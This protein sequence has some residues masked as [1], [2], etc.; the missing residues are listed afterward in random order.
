MDFALSPAQQEIKDRAAGFAAREVALHA[1]EWDREARFPAEVFE[2]LSGAG[3]MGLCVP[4]EY[5]GAG[6][7]FLSYVLLIEEISRAD[8]G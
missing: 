3:F 2:K 6:E 5:G 1:A 7:D 4:E 8:A